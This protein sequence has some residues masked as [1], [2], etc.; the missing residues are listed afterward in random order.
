M[1][2]FLFRYL[3]IPSAASRLKATDYGPLLDKISDLIK[4]WTSLTLSSTGRLE[5][6]RLVVQGVSCYW[7]AIFPIPAVVIDRIE[8]MCRRFLWGS[9]MGRVAWRH[10]C[11]PK[12]EGGLGL[13]DIRSWNKALLAKTLWNIHLKKDTLW[14]KWVNEL[15]L[16]GNSIWEWVPKAD[17]PPIFKNLAELEMRWC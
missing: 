8:G 5:L 4:A 11:L 9:N 2:A 3:R 13:R 6:I 15:F 7:F 17:S 1:G 16:H 10:V 12:V 14:I